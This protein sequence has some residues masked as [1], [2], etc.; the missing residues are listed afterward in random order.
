MMYIF[1]WGRQRERD[2]G[3]AYVCSNITDRVHRGRPNNRPRTCMRLILG[4]CITCAD[5]FSLG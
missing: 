2:R 3:K 5:V 4:T 1:V